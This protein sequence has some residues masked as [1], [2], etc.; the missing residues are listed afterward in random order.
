VASEESLC[1]KK[2]SERRQGKGEKNMITASASGA[3]I[4]DDI[5]MEDIELFSNAIVTDKNLPIIEELYR[6]LEDV[7]TVKTQRSLAG[8]VIL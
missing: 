4:I 7:L 8:G 1:G 6:E 5:I 2:D 3:E